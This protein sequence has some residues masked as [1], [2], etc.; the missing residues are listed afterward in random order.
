MENRILREFILK[1]LA[2]DLGDGDHSSLACIPAEAT[3]KAKLLIK[4]KGL[5]AGI[6]IAR[7]VFSTIDKDLK[8]DVLLDDGPLLSREILH[9]IFRPAAINS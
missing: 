1:S 5:L 2:E 3:G 7:E 8:F 4:E 6:R 9:F